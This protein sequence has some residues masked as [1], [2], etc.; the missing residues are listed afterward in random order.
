MLDS[1][2]NKGP[3]AAYSLLEPLPLDVVVRSP[4]S[5]GDYRNYPVFSS[6]WLRRRTLIFA[7]FAAGIGLFQALL[8][9]ASLNDWG[10]AA[11]CVAV[12]VPSWIAIVTAGPLLAT[13]VRHR[14]LPLPR[15]RIAVVGAIAVGLGISFAVQYG[16]NAFSNATVTPYYRAAMG[17]D[18][19]RKMHRP[20]PLLITFVT[21]WQFALFSCLGGGLALRTY[22]DEQK[23]WRDAQRER[24]MQTL[25]HEKNQADLRLTVLQA[26]VEPHFLF[27][28]LA[29]IHSLI[30]Q[31]PQRAEATV[32]ALV[33]HLRATVPK[34]RAGI[35][36]AHSTLAEQIEVCESYLAVMQVRMGSRLG[37]AIDVPE[38]L[39]QHPFPPLMLISLVEN[40]IKHGVEPSAAGGNISISAVIEDRGVV[41]QLAVSVIDD[42]VG[43]QP[44]MGSG[45]GLQNIA[46]Q[47]EARYGAHGEL[48]IRNRPAGGVAATIRIPC[49]EQTA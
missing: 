24:E 16:A 3:R 46:A 2:T 20:T 49:T 31:D 42:G 40:A 12:G 23:R 27:N 43:L 17:E 45:I 13:I 36:N 44:G 26:Q 47:L 39:R 7:P 4:G 29:S 8:V 37:Y 35:G 15:E 25:R 1:A 22:F 30:R 11:L 41:R 48:L 21:L 38:A 33:D 6:P 34:L 19:F 10:L 28:T 32:E 9:G 18:A 14:G 5:L